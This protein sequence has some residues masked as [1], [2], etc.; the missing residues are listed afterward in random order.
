VYPTWKINNER[1]RN[2]A[3]RILLTSNLKQ[4][5]V[6]SLKILTEFRKHVGIFP[7]ECIH[8]L[9]VFNFGIHHEICCYKV[10]VAM[11]NWKQ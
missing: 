7:P 3:Q 1:L 6:Y 2:S 10:N 11:T 4:C 9:N 8:F 5:A